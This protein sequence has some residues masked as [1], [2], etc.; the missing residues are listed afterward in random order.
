[1]SMLVEDPDYRP[2]RTLGVLIENGGGEQLLIPEAELRQ[3]DALFANSCKY[4]GK[5]FEPRRGSGGKPQKFCS[6]KCRQAYHAEH[7]QQPPPP[8]EKVPVKA[9][10]IS[11]PVEDEDS[12]DFTWSGR[13]AADVLIP[14]QPAIAVYFNPHG[15][16]VIRQEGH[17]G[18]DEDQ[19]IYLQIKNL[20]PLIAKLSAIA[21]GDIVPG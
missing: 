6:S 18:P 9:P 8:V 7:E 14:H 4:C 17:F 16:V 13:D 15:E 5:D 21:R 1:M 12:R 3:V 20:D 19:F 2:G 10:V 11:A